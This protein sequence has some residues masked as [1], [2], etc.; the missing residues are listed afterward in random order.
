[1]IIPMTARRYFQTN[2][3][4]SSLLTMVI[5]LM[6]ILPQLNGQSRI[7]IAIQAGL[8]NSDMNYGHEYLDNILPIGDYRSS[9]SGGQSGRGYTFGAT[10][11]IPL[12][13]QMYGMAG[14]NY[15]EYRYRVDGEVGMIRPGIGRPLSDNIPTM[16]DGNL[17]YRF[18]ELQTGIMY[19]AGS[20]P[21]QGFFGS[22]YLSYLVHLDQALQLDAVYETGGEGTLDGSSAINGDDLDNLWMIG[23]DVGFRIPMTSWISFGPKLSFQLSLNPVNSSTIPPISSSGSLQLVG[24]F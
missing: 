19:H 2:H 5:S 20:N 3:R 6:T 24:V 1:M 17:D 11:E 16:V 12:F 15:T 7:G 18:L 22:L 23:A 4:I 13:Q 21:G 14:I 8:N 9:S 10:A